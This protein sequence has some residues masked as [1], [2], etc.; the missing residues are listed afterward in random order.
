MWLSNIKRYRRE[1]MST[2]VIDKANTVWGIPSV[3]LFFHFSVFFS[4]PWASYHRVCI[5]GPGDFPLLVESRHLPQLVFPRST[6][7]L[8]PEERVSVNSAVRYY[9][10]ADRHFTIT[11]SLFLSMFTSLIQ[12]SSE[13]VE[14]MSWVHPCK[15]GMLLWRKPH[16]CLDPILCAASQPKQ[17][18]LLQWRWL[19]HC[20]EYWLVTHV[21]T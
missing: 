20:G 3:D 15:Q 5:E 4:S 14:G 7:T 18:H 6:Q 12:V 13:W 2:K 11:A 1:W 17:Y 10:T 16:I 8:L 21:S 9:T 19:F